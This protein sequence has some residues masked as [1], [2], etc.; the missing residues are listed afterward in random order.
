MKLGLD[1]DHTLIDYGPLLRELTIERGLI[2]P[3]APL[4]TKQEI[5]DAIR[6]L[7]E[8]DLRWQQIQSYLYA[9]G[10][11]RA[12]P[13]AGLEQLFEF[14]RRNQIETWIVSH[15]T[16]TAPFDPAQRNLREAALAWMEAQGFF[17]AEKF[18]LRREKVRFADTK[19][20]KIEIIRAQNFTVFV[21][22]LREILTDPLFPIGPR[23]L[24]YSTAAE[25]P[26]GITVHATWPALVSELQHLRAAEQRTAALVRAGYVE[27][28][29]RPVRGGRNSRAFHVLPRDATQAPL[30]LKEY[31]RHPRDPRDR[32]ATEYDAISFMR[33]QQIDCVPSARFADPAANVAAYSYIAGEPALH[34]ALS[35]GD[36]DALLAFLR[37]LHAQ[38]TAAAARTLPVASEACFCLTDLTRQ[39]HGRFERLA[40]VEHEAL[41]AFLASITPL[42]AELSAEAASGLLEQDRSP[43]DPLPEPFRT[44]SPSD[45]GFHNAIRQA[46][47]QLVFVDFEYFGWDDPAK[48]ISDFLLQPEQQLSEDLRQRFIAGAFAIYPDPALP[49]RLQL[50]FP[51]FRLKW[52]AI[53]LN[54]FLRDAAARRTFANAHDL[55]RGDILQRQLDKARQMAAPLLERQA[56]PFS[57]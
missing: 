45:I 48:L 47:G 54:E 44:L 21:D 10:V 55:S 51:L 15:K 14:V 53:L 11:R 37:Q 43:D 19:A 57:L 38:R 31:F 8:G 32:L 17:S 46:D 40:A 16:T 4:H 2:A 52:I 3:D 7:P 1:F 56:S 13:A 49:A 29:H 42:I 41:Q 12:V 25:A 27:A 18:G 50:V 34:T 6:R 30:F 5:R 35:S 24:L 33:A 20:Q 28:Q 26:A 36:I 39:L 23:R 9:E 22:D